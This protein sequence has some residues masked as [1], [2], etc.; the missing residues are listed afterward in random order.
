M[1]RLLTSA[2]LVAASAA[3][4]QQEPFFAS[5]LLPQD[6]YDETGP[7]RIQVYV[8][9]PAGVQ[10]IEVRMRDQPVDP[11]DEDGLTFA[12]K[13]FEP[14][15]ADDEEGPWVVEI[16][17]RP[18]GTRFW[19]QLVLVEETTGSLVRDPFDAPDSLHFFEILTRD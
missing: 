12:K 18:A 2:L 16:D 6:T 14:L 11:S 8:V 5:V 9:A 3:C 15:D 13:R 4:V 10:R 7:Y 1:V 17:G 19:Y